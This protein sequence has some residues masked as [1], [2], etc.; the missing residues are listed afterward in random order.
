MD[1]K[2]VEEPEYIRLG[3]VEMYAPGRRALQA[4]VRF[5]SGASRVVQTSSS[6]QYDE[7]PMRTAARRLQLSLAVVFVGLL[8]PAPAARGADTLVVDFETG[9]A[10]DTPIT[11]E[12]LS[13]H[14]LRFIKDD[15]GFRPYRRSAPGLAR[16]GSVV[17][18][19]GGSVCFPESGDAVGCEFPTVGTTGRL[20]RTASSV[21][22][23]AGLFTDQGPV[24]ARLVVRNASDQVVATGAFV[25]VDLLG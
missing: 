14:F 25:P 12:Y 2:L 6:P 4:R 18:D 20:T 3:A 16:S 11:D 10:L 21:T 19:V 15:P 23:D 1:F 13:S 22:L 7:T 17:A 8:L 9:P 24:L 5:S